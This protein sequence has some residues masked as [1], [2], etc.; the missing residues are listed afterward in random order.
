MEFTYNNNY[1]V[2]I[3]MVP[4]EMLYGRKCRLLSYWT[5]VGE[6]EITGSN[7]M[8]EITEKIKVIQD[9]LKIAK[10]LCRRKQKRARFSRKRLGILENLANEESCEICEE[11]KVKST[12][13]ETI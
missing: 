12:L 8:L 7:I 5:E 13:C 9:R 3:G 2:S 11:G 4:F 10:E 6:T 1:Q